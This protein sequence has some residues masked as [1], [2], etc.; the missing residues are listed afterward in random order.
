ME[1]KSRVKKYEEL[2]ETLLKE[3]QE[4]QETPKLSRFAKRLSNIDAD[5]FLTIES[6]ITNSLGKW[7]IINI[8]SNFFV[9][10]LLFYSVSLR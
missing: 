2:R 4:V 9:L 8:Y 6:G 1:A 3:N 7:I 10:P 5:Y